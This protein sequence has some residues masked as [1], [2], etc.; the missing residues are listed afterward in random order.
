MLPLLR[1]EVFTATRMQMTALWNIAL[2]SL[3]EQ[4]DVLDLRIASIV[5]NRPDDGGS[6]QML[7]AHPR[8]NNCSL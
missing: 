6:K 8:Y 2:C 5:R 3:V 4:T 7:D 1:L